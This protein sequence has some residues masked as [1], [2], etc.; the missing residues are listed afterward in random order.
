MQSRQAFVNRSPATI[1]FDLDGTLVDTAPDL[2]RAMNHVLRHFGRREVDAAEVRDLVG[3]GA[4]RTL[5]R[6]LALTGGGDE[7]LLDVG[8]P[9]FLEHYTANL[10]AESRA[11]PGVEAALERLEA[12]GHVLGICTNKPVRLAEQLVEALG[13][14][15]RFAAILG[16]DSLAV[17]KPDPAPVH[18]TIARAHGEIARAVFVGDSRVD[19]DAARAAGL[20]IIVTAFGYS[21]VPARELGADAVL[22]AFADLLP[23][24]AR[25]APAL[26]AR[27]GAVVSACP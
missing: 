27:G 19:V 20:P 9:L 26:F 8:V 14:G 13:W 18:E 3:H 11:W 21:E 12:D 23:A 2:T 7:A 1:V 22:D 15:G 5:A 10:C 16:G 6:G 4:R 24:L 17:R 25:V